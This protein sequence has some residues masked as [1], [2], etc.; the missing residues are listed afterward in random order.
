MELTK[1]LGKKLL[2]L[3]SSDASNVLVFVPWIL[4]VLSF[5]PSVEIPSC[6]IQLIFP[7]FYS[8]CIFSFPLFPTK[9]PYYYI[10]I[11]PH[12]SISLLIYSLIFYAFFKL[13]ILDFDA[14]VHSLS[15]SLSR[16]A[17]LRFWV[18]SWI[19][20][21]GLDLKYWACNINK[22]LIMFLM[23]ISKNIGK[24]HNIAIL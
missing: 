8:F 10:S 18:C 20:W 14:V 21:A 4:R 11:F 15:F 17:S 2:I 24:F 7:Q 13:I 3:V 9:H 1:W 5:A 23:R 6:C 16:P 22:C 19:F 12:G